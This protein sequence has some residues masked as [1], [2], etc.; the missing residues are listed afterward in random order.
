MARVKVDYGIDLGTTNSAIARL[1][2]GDVKIIK[3]D[4]QKDTMPSCVSFRKNTILVGDRA[5]SRISDEHLTAFSDFSR[6]GN[7]NHEFNTF[8]EFKRNMG[9]DMVYKNVSA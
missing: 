3:S 4:L 1:E 7:T 6:T 2:N 5:F 9:T 8:I